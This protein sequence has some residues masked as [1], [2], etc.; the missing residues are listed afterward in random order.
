[1]CQL[2]TAV[3]KTVPLEL[4]EVETICETHIKS[5]MCEKYVLCDRFYIILRKL[6]LK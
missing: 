5:V 3:C 2:Q 1:M 4:L 6:K